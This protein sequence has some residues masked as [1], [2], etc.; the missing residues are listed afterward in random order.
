MQLYFSRK[1]SKEE[2]FFKINEEECVGS[3][4]FIGMEMARSHF[5]LML[6]RKL[7]ALKV[8]REIKN[9]YKYRSFSPP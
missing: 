9:L 6:T 3:G 1:I 5:F 4:K 7:S 2:I 8:V